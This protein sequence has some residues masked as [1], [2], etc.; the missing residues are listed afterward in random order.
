MV[1]LL[2]S[3]EGNEAEAEKWYTEAVRID[4]RTPVAANNLAWIYVQRG[5][6]LD[7]ALA[8]AQSAVAA[9]PGDL[10]PADTL[11]WGYYKA[12]MLS[13][14][15]PVLERCVKEAPDNPLYQFHLGMAYAKRGHDAKARTALQTALKLKADFPGAADARQTLTQLAY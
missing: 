13:S 7:E 6:K 15:I 12:G 5:S 11:G 9:L 10:E 14:A 3:F 8:L 1:G 4:S 2:F